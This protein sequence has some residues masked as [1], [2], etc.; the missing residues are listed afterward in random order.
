MTFSQ[1]FL[2]KCRSD[3]RICRWDGRNYRHSPALVLLKK[4]GTKVEYAWFDYKN[5][6][7][8]II[9][10]LKGR[11]LKKGE[12]VAIIAL[13]LPE[14]FFAILGAIFMGAVPV[15]INFMLLKNEGG[16]E[17]LKKI[18]GDCKPR[19]I[20]G[21]AALKEFLPE[22]C[23]LIKQI[24][25]E[26]HEIIKNL[27]RGPKAKITVLEPEA[28]N[29]QDLF[30]MPYTSGTTGKPKWV[31]LNED[32]M[33]DRVSATMAELRV[34]DQERVPSYLPLGHIAELVATFFGQIHSGYTIYFTEHIEERIKNPD[35]FTKE[36]PPFLQQVQ[37]TIFLG[38]PKIWIHFRQG[39]EKK[40]KKIPGVSF[41]R[42]SKTVNNFL[43]RQTKKQLGFQNTR[44]FISAA[45]PINDMGQDGIEFFQN[46]EINLNDIYG[47][48]ETGGPILINGQRIG[49]IVAMML[50]RK[51]EQEIIIQGQCLML[52]YYNNPEA[53]A[54]VLGDF[55]NNGKFTYHTGDACKWGK[56]ISGIPG[57]G[58]AK[59][60][61]AGRLDD[62]FKGADGEYRHASKIYELENKLKKIKEVE[63]AIVCG[64]GKLF[65]VALIFT[66]KTFTRGLPCTY[67]AKKVR[68]RCLEIGEGLYKIKACYL[69]NKDGLE[70]TATMKLKRKE[71]IKK[72]Q[73]V[74][75]TLTDR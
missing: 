62:G 36:F 5:R 55:N 11:N 10:G 59:L 58:L 24:L 72:F 37:P 66:D 14:S 12:F 19:I 52:G 68:Q 31:M 7:L 42:K 49:N 8:Q 13:N 25:S 4:D 44:I 23:V 46:L 39:I 69:A 26:G 20:L 57:Q 15:P 45:A 41:L 43:I 47:Q 70:Y 63:E 75:N 51:E 2:E 35:K 27:N 33:I 67:L 34:S 54:K 29:S 74:I 40:L 6:V 71:V 17:E 32:G 28:R 3:V 48:T 73:G 53:T 1:L 22:D 61:Y 56:S 38:V 64:E 30:I 9:E 21:N 65:L 50:I 16:R 18:L 60:L